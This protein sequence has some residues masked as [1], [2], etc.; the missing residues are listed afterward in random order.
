MIWMTEGRRQV[1]GHLYILYT[2]SEYE[3]IGTQT[4]C[5]NR[6]RGEKLEVGTPP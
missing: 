1:Y 4:L 6:A 5:E 2:F 3:W